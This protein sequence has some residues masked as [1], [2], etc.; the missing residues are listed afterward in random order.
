MYIVFLTH[1]FPV[2][3][4]STTGA[5]NYVANMAQIMQKHGH[6]VSIITEA[7]NREIFNWNGIEVR[8]IKAT[9]GFKNTGRPMP[10]YQKLLKN[11]SRSI[12]YN[13]EVFRISRKNKIDIVQSVSSYGLA[14]LRIK[15]IPYVVR[16]SE[17]MPLWTRLRKLDYDYEECLRSKRIDEE[18][19][20]IGLKRADILV[21]PSFLMEKLIY[22]K[23]KKKSIVIESPVIL[24]DIDSLK[25]SEANL[26]ENK[27]WITYGAMNYRK[28][29]HIVAQI[30]DD[31]L[32]KY[33]EMKYV[34]AGKDIEIFY[35]NQF[36][37]VS[38]FFDIHI[39]KNKDRF[40]F[41][42]E[43]SDRKRLFSIVKS[44]YACVLPTRID[45]LP[46]TCLES[47]ALGKIVISSTCERG[48]SIE[49]LIV[50][51]YSGFL[52]QVDDEKSLYNKIVQAMQLS[53]CEKQ[54][55]EQR[56][57]ERVKNSMPE[58]VYESMMKVYSNVLDN[59][60]KLYRR[61]NCD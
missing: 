10:T 6:R 53:N 54:S 61:N 58:N 23:I 40:M 38:S 49:Q 24:E 47:M 45:N 17:Y 41:L 29:I 9:R 1:D 12:W 43:I 48:T 55:M 28:E 27:Y 8:K 60:T 56:S 7:E 2:R 13:W 20:F 50:D 33:P 35:N 26:T 59:S 44:A 25:L 34:V 4:L 32:D 21:S 30:I 14:M 57:M 39:K 18:I 46:N 42:G 51:G 52:A 31:L 37:K 19:T 16:V 5:G 11:I 36:M 3:G 22:N 15:K